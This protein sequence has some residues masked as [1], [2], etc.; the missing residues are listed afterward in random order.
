MP[1][2][3]VSLR[4]HIVFSTKYRAATIAPLWIA[5]LHALLGGIVRDVGGVALEVGGV[6]DHVHLLVG[7]NATHA[8][9]DA[10]R[11]GKKRSSAWVHETIGERRF[12][13]QEG[14]GAF[15]VGRD[16]CGRV[17]GYIRNQAEHHRRR[18]YQEEYRGFLDEQGIVFDER[19]LW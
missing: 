16:G 10:V 18:S 17:A 9:A 5:R 1:S 13:G 6:R 3:H 7:L 19:Y 2:T 14:Y 4:Y 12:A 8:V 15:T 11:E